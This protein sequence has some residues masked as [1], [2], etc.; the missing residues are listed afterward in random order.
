MTMITADA[1]LSR[2]PR[3][4]SVTVAFWLQV[5]AVGLLLALIGVLVAHA[6]YFDDQISRAVALVPDADPLEVSDERSGNLY[7]AVVPG[8]LLLLMA[9][10]LAVTAVPMRRGRNVARILVF[11]GAGAHALVCLAPCA[12]GFMAIPFLI[13]G[14]S[15]AAPDDVPMDGVPW[16]ESRFLETL[17]GQ[18][19]SFD[20]A[21]FGGIAIGTGLELLLVITIAI[22]IAVP[23]AHRYFVPRPPTPA[24]PAGYAGYPPMAGYAGVPP[25]AGYAGYAPGAGYAGYPPAGG[26]AGHP[27]SGP[28]PW[29]GGPG[30]PAPP[31]PGPFVICP[32]PAA[33]VTPPAAPGEGP[34]PEGD[35]PAPV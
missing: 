6:I 4:A 23:P 10:W 32:D 19:T 7:G 25:L 8:A 21:F 24:W 34:R 28:Q 11:V 5:G 27:E 35:P 29:P 3:P 33:H 20:D 15:E 30:W 12:A 18:T 2:P 22:L 31:Y 17:Y 9:V 1:R 14:I 13:G 26:Y 16:E